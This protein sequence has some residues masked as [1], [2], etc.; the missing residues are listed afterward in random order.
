MEPKTVIEGQN[1]CLNSFKVKSMDGR[2]S[3]KKRLERYRILHLLSRVGGDC[4]SPFR[5][6]SHGDFTVEMCAHEQ[7][8]HT[9]WCNSRLAVGTYTKKGN[10]L[11]LR[12]LG[13]PSG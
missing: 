11:R 13:G 2:Y 9:R 5:R 7:A 1:F 4:R 6:V 10:E 3:V 12:Q 8:W